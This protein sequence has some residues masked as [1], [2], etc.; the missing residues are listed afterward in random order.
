MGKFHVWSDSESHVRVPDEL[1]CRVFENV[2]D[3]HNAAMDFTYEYDGKPFRV[4]TYV[5]DL[6]KEETIE[7][8]EN[9][10]F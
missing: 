3:A 2:E 5:E 7:V 4:I 1:Y 10:P 6:D 9:F 8:I